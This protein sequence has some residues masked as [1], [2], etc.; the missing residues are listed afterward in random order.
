MSASA[1][2]SAFRES[3]SRRGSRSAP[4]RSSKNTRMI[5]CRPR[6]VANRTGVGGDSEFDNEN[7][8]AERSVNDATGVA[9]RSSRRSRYAHSETMQA[10]AIGRINTRF[11]MPIRLQ[12][13]EAVMQWRGTSP[14]RKQGFERR[15]RARNPCLRC[16]L[17]VNPCR[18]LAS[19]YESYWIHSRSVA[20]TSAAANTLASR[21]SAHTNGMSNNFRDRH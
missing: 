17:V 11:L 6:K 4:S 16:G 15:L 21:N 2:R 1:I 13:N 3:H 10:A 5:R 7:V 14:P 8:V 12:P 19:R 20:F 9:G 18:R